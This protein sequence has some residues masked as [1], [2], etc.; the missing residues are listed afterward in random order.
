MCF[1]AI[2]FN[3]TKDENT[4]LIN[5]IKD[6]SKLNDDGFGVIYADA[7]DKKSKVYRE[8]EY[9]PA[10]MADAAKAQFSIVHLRASTGG[11]VTKENVH[12]WRIGNWVFAH[13]GT[14]TKL[15][16]D[17]MADSYVFFRKVIEEKLIKEDKLD[18][19]MIDLLA[20]ENSLWGRFLFY[21]DKTGQAVTFGDWEAKHVNGKSYLLSAD[22]KMK[23]TIVHNG[24]SFEKD[25]SE[26]SVKLEG[27]NY[28]DVRSLVVYSLKDECL[29]NTYNAKKYTSHWNKK[30]T[31]TTP[32][33]VISQRALGFHNN[34]R[35]QMMED[36]FG[37]SGGNMHAC[38]TY[39]NI[40]EGMEH[41]EED[42]IL[43]SKRLLNGI[44]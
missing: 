10:A 11:T 13:N 25:A 28:I 40:E 8:V 30:D 33:P 9:S 24:I 17:K 20:D 37:E 44:M 15:R 22:A 32:P 26:Y 2:T 16:D 36:L 1:I 41:Q 34:D 43:E 18:Y 42:I 12:L 7:E 35:D 31:A 27:I 3:E 38:I 29:Y 5:L 6:K 4:E 19:D 23:S 21:N 39:E 14:V